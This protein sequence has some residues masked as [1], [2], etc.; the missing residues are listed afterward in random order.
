MC[1]LKF[2]LRPS[3]NNILDTFPTGTAQNTAHHQEAVTLCSAYGIYHASALTSCL[4]VEDWFF[5]VNWARKVHLV[6]S[7]VQPTRRNVFSIYLF[8]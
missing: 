1:K 5:G 2:K 7:K 8:L 3:W 4:Q 6:V